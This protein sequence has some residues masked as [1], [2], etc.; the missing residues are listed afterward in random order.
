M[1]DSYIG[2]IRMFAGNY[3][4]VDW[5]LC[6]GSLLAISQYQVLYA[7]IGTTYGGDGMNTFALPDLRGRVPVSTGQ[8]PG[9]SNYVLGQPFGTENVTL[10]AATMPTHNHPFNATSTGATSLK[11]TPSGSMTLATSPSNTYLYAKQTTPPIPVVQL[12]PT[13]VGAAG[14][15]VSHTNIMP[16]LAINYIIALTGIYPQFN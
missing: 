5:H 1:A 8:G 4:P 12:A 11:P 14:G 15:N 3:A 2:E 16:V 13:D 10:T 7:L 6:D 9:L